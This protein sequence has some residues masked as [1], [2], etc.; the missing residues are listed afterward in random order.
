[1]N[2][3]S[4]LMIDYIDLSGKI[5]YDSLIKAAIVARKKSYCKYSG[6]AVGAALLTDDGKVFKGCNIENVAFGPSICAE[7]VAFFKSL[8]T[9]ENINY[10]YKAIAV[11]GGKKDDL[12]LD[13][14]PPC[15]V[16]RQV[17]SEFCNEN[18]EIVL[19]RIEGE[20]V[21]DYK[22]Y[23]LKDLLPLSFDDLE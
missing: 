9:E 16:C 10:K 4:N 15:G 3:N 19:A 20:K 1:M 21:L 22:V 5:I 13:F 23:L 11:V 2:N 14:C 6:F 18:F 12:K 7:R 8:S 17:M